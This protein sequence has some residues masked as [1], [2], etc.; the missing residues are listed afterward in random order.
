MDTVF[1]KALFCTSEIP[2]SINAGSMQL[3]RVL[4]GYPGDRLLVLGPPR[5]P[6]A[7]LLSCRYEVLKLLT[8]RLACTRF[9]EWTSG[10]N[11]LNTFIEP[12]IGRSMKLAR[13]FEP[14]LIVTVMDKLSYYKHAWALARRLQVPLVTITMDDPQTF[15]RSTPMLESAFVS[16][17]RCMY[18]DASL[19]LAISKEMSDY[20]QEKF[21]R[22]SEV[23]YFGPPEDI[24]RRSPEDSRC[25]KAPPN[26]TLGY[27]GSLGLGYRDG[28][29]AICDALASTR[30]TLNIYTRDQHC[31]VDHPQIV[32]RG[33]FTS[34]RLWPIV[35]SECDAVLL[36]YAFEGQMTR[37]Y[38]THF[39]T[40]LSEYCWL[41]M[42]I[43][44]TGPEDATGV[45][46]AL[47]HS[48]AARAAT[49]R[50]TEA[51]A[52]FFRQIRDDGEERMA[53]A[54][55]SQRIA[56]IEFDPASIRQQF[57]A[58]L[59]AASLKSGLET[60]SSTAN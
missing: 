11:A 23:F 7:Q 43:I 32:N 10:L 50:N 35:Q 37:V 46:W 15:E 55:A 4:Q 16:F 14:D 1:P 6:D 49:S 52:H 17:L 8:Y 24:Q 25:L 53:M 39:P 56:E 29:L 26:L 47:R 31:L 34:D 2:Q 28:L 3:F 41:G 20:L 60:I 21:G 33:F 45:R 12:Q 22:K 5:E 57:V 13:E 18:Q 38:R 40:K 30:T 19:S 54:S 44:V 48:D 36:P 9:R 58:L 27:A 51:L 59:R 42:P